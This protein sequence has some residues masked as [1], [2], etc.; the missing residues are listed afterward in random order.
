MIGFR[1]KKK[2]LTKINLI[3]IL[4]AVFIFIF[5]LLMSAQFVD[6]HEIGSDA[7]AITTIDTEKKDSK[8][9]LNLI[10]VIEDQSFIIKTGLNEDIYKSIPSLD[11]KYNFK[12]L[13]STLREIKAKNIEEHSIIMK[14]KS[15]IPYNQLV[16]IMDVVRNVEVNEKKIAGKKSNGEV[17]YTNSMF[18][19]II[20]ET[21]I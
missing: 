3:P 11:K 15:T 6:I 10:L 8:K 4:D 9:P 7:P 16:L 14:P 13:S 19:Q 2:G 20:F 5:F 17:I 12:L 18:K 1:R 21:I